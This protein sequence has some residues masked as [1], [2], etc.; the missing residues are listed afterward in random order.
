M[1]L[2]VR[3][4]Q[5]K[6]DKGLRT[7]CKEAMIFPRCHQLDAVR[8]LVAHAKA[9]GAGRNYLVQHSAG[10]GKSNSIAWLSHRLASLHDKHDVKVFHSVIVVTDRRVLDQQLQSTI[11]QFEHKTGV[12]EKSTRT[13]SSLH[14]PCPKARPSSSRLFRSFPLSLKHSRPLRRRDSV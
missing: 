3:E 13:P 6:T 7:V 2:E 9:K 1:H 8:K 12:V 4:T 5:V 11:Y 10:S 14:R